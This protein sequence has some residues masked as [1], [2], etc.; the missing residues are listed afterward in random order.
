MPVNLK[1]D[2][3]TIG[4][5]GKTVDNR[6]ITVDMVNDIVDLYDPEQYKAVVRWEHYRFMKLGGVEALRKV[7]NK[8]GGYDVQ[9]I[10]SPNQFWLD[11]NA[12]DQKTFTSMELDKVDKFGGRWYLTGLGATDN[13]ASFGTTELRFSKQNDTVLNGEPVEFQLDIEQA[14]KGLFSRLFGKQNHED[15]AVDKETLKA[16]LEEMKG[17]RTELSA[18]KP[19]GGKPTDPPAPAA[20]PKDDKFTALEARFT[21]LEAKVNELKPADPPAPAADPNAEKFT[22]LEAR[23]TALEQKFTEALNTPHPGTTNAPKQTGTEGDR[24]DYL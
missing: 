17:M 14:S 22:A 16:L 15:S 3:K 24:K 8:E 20:D 6:E 11:E 7:K 13:P 1:T 18:L 12:N 9:A 2:W 10:L 5:T 21:A 19:D 4:R 23:F